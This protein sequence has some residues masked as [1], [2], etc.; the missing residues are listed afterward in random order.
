MPFILFLLS[1]IAFDQI[2]KWWVVTTLKPIG[3][4][5]VIQDVFHFT[6]AEN[7]GAAFSIFKDKQIFLVLTTTLIIAF[8]GGLL[9]KALKVPGEVH[10]LY[11]IAL[12]MVIGGAIGNLIDRIRLNYVIDFL[13]ARIIN[14]AIFNVADSFVVVGTIFIAYLVL[15]KDLKI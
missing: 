13:D 8:A 1:I 4:I 2:T 10:W 12:T 15:F 11:P 5:P 3:T 7:T 14:F 6:Y 9:Y